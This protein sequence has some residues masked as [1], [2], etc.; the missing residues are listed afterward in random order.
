MTNPKSRVYYTFYRLGERLAKIIIDEIG[1]EF[2]TQ[3]T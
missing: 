1:G 2:V 3:T